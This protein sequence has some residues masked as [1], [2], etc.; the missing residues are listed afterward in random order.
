VS[1]LL[2][3]PLWLHF[4]FFPPFIA[5][6]YSFLLLRFQA[7]HLSGIMKLTGKGMGIWYIT[8]KRKKGKPIYLNLW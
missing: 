2:L 3:S 4:H 6:L 5:I 8:V 7:K 1:P